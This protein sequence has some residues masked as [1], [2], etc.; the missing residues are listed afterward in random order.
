M[1][2]FI[3]KKDTNV[4]WTSTQNEPFPLS[5]VSHSYDIEG[6]KEKNEFFETIKSGKL[7]PLKH[8]ITGIDYINKN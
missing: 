1:E 5:T 6:Q 3:F 2:K 7:P 8:N 4:D